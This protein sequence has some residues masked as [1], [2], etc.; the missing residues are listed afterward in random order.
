MKNLMTATTLTTFKKVAFTLLCCTVLMVFSAPAQTIQQMKA[1]PYPVNL[2]PPAGAILDLNGTP[3]PGVP[4]GN[5]T[6]KQYMVNFTASSSN[7]AC[8][9]GAPCTTVITFAFR[10]DPAQISFANALV[11]DTADETQTN[12]LT[13]GN[14]SEGLTGWTYVNTYGAAVEPGPTGYVTSY[15]GY[16]YTMAY[17]WFD[18]TVQAY[19]AISQTIPTTVGHTYQI[20]F[21]VAE[22]SETFAYPGQ[23]DAGGAYPQGFLGSDCY[24]A[25]QGT[26]DQFP[27]NFRDLST[28][29]DTADGGGNGIDVVVYAQASV[30][31]DQYTL[32]LTELGTGIGTVTDNQSPQQ[33]N[34]TEA[35]GI[36]QP[37]STC[38]G[39]YASG[40]QV[41]LTAA[42]SPLATSITPTPA[43]ANGSTFL[44]W[45]SGP[46]AGTM[47]FT[48]SFTV[49]SAQTVTA[50]FAPTPTA[51]PFT[52][53]GTN[54]TANPIYACPS[55]TNPCTD[56]NAYA[57]SVQF[58][59]V[60]PAF[61]DTP[62][63]IL[64]T[65]VYATGICP[66]GQFSLYGYEYPTPGE[67][68]DFDCRL[69]SFFDYG[70]DAAGDYVVPL[71]NAYAN[72]NCV[73]YLVYY[74]TQGNVPPTTSYTGPVF[75]AITYNNPSTPAA[76]SFWYGSI[77]RT[78]VDPDADEATPS[79]P[80]GTNCN[81][82]M[83][84]EGGSGTTSPAIYC[85]FDEDAT[86]FFN[87]SAPV[88]GG[89]GSKTQQ[90]N[91]FVVAFQPTVEPPTQ[92]PSTPIPAQ[93]APQLAGTCVNG[94]TDPSGT[95][96]FTEGTGGTFEV[97]VTAGYPAP[98]LSESGTLPLGL[99][100]NAATG[101]ISGTPADGTAGGNYPIT[102]TATN[103]KGS[104]MLGYTLTVAAVPLT[105][106]ASASMT[107]GGMVPMITPTVTG[108]VNGDLPS[109]VS[110]SSAATSSSPAG[111][112]PIS[113]TVSASS[114]YN[115][116]C[117][118]ACGYVTVNRA[119][120][121]I[122]ASSATIIYGATVPAITPAFT[123]NG[124]VN[125]DTQ[126]SLG[127]TCLTTATSMSVPGS[128]PSSCTAS[129]GS[130]YMI[131]L[132]GGTVTVVG[133]DVSPLTVNFGNLYLY[134]I[135][136]QG[137]ILK[138]TTLVP[139][140]INSITHGGGSANGDFGDVAL[141]PPMILKLPAT[142]PAGK[143]CAIG[144]GILATAQVFNPNP[145]Y[146]YLTINEGAVIQ[147]VLLTALVT[148]PVVSLSTTSLSFGNEKTGTT[149][150]AQKVTLTNSGLTPL[151]LTGLTISANFAFASGTTCTALPLLSPG[152]TCLIYVN[153]TPMSKGTKYSGSVTITD[154]TLIGKQTISLSG[155]GD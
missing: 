124:L 139:I 143:S 16:C 133:L 76:G 28:N 99:T 2:G 53:S 79:V 95:I 36:Q 34:C 63:Y 93:V 136:V 128:Y 100:F 32:T 44:G 38:T 134:G 14:F 109:I 30:P 129:M 135:G 5:G 12:L 39:T 120:L 73:H 18:G 155:T 90:P 86:T 10:D 75:E 145:S 150:V 97:S 62:L 137:I 46:C 82:P 56:T 9:P 141:C 50:D 35:N 13:N 65:E 119:P 101:L 127:V 48:C 70:T 6:Y 83:S 72:G 59:A 31:A 52:L 105:I 11:F 23:P 112:Y 130:N 117:T 25:A 20:S 69:V 98:S 7:T 96:T 51:V 19:D 118:A 55:Q 125:G 140:M 138:N 132:V 71:C 115:V 29:G 41:T 154:K 110:C 121:T 147:Q 142:L 33:I 57:M 45:I 111:S 61:A 107:Y 85:Q 146:T 8:T 47:G 68:T 27:C 4:G 3:I 126:T 103:S 58:P 40:T 1:D 37:L 106:M 123:N 149:S 153:F 21:D 102:F 15:S 43:N 84:Q 81:D 64:A 88:D 22:D 42:P 104:A 114:T 152:G 49:S 80:W 144:V 67:T 91:D 89:S 54:A 148:D 74:G 66:A 78:I 26:P 108:L 151:T 94:C 122:T 60:T 113:C 17:C 87:S 116:S 92:N 77:S 131:T 24:L